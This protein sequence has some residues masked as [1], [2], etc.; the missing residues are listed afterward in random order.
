MVAVSI[1]FEFPTTKEPHYATVKNKTRNSGLTS[2]CFADDHRL[3]A[4]DF[5][6]QMLYLVNINGDKIDF[7]ASH[8]TQIS[9]GTTVQTDLM[10]VHDDRL[11]VTNF[12]QGSVSFYRFTKNMIQFESE[13]NLNPHSGLHG[14]RF[15][16]GSPDLVWLTYC[17]PKFRRH[18]IVDVA[19]RSVLHDFEVDQQCQDVAFVGNFAVVFARTNHIKRGTE[20][21]PLLSRRRR[22]FATAYVYRLPM[23]LRTS[24]PEFVSRWKGNG[25]IDA[26][27]GS[28][29]RIYAANQYLDR[30]DVFELSHDGLLA[31]NSK[32][33]GLKMPHGID[34]RGGKLAVTNYGDQTLRILDI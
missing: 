18:Q 16:P 32:I 23:N 3:V 30:I 11:A 19:A 29:N 25:H 21:V 17:N 5:N 7:V 2:V 26:T 24:P 27:K 14:V 33:K 15:V 34:V 13:L 28:G 4:A 20:K 9:D 6:E 1:A 8:P 22:M 12:Y 10:D 31:L